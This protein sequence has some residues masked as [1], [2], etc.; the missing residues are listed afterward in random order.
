MYAETEL[1]IEP[2]DS[3]EPTSFVVITCHVELTNS[4]VPTRWILPSGQII[5]SSFGRYSVGQGANENG[6]W[7]TLL[8]VQNVSYRD[9]GHYTCEVVPSSVLRSQCEC[10]D[11]PFSATTELLL[12]GQTSSQVFKVRCAVWWDFI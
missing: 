1:K 4:T 12:Q 5:D 7:S 6:V 10:V 11:F 2:L 3:R 9:A 8:A